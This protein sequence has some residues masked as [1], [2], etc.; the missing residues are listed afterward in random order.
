M[1]GRTPTAAE[2]GSL[3]AERLAWSLVRNVREHPGK[4][5][6]QMPTLERREDG[7]VRLSPGAALSP[8][9]DMQANCI[10]HAVDRGRPTDGGSADGEQ[11]LARVAVRHCGEDRSSRAHVLVGLSRD[12][13]GSRPGWE[14][15]HWQEQK[16]R[17]LSKRD[18]LGVRLVAMESHEGVRRGSVAICLS[19]LTDEVDLDHVAESGVGLH[20]LLHG[21]HEEDMGPGQEVDSRHRHAAEGFADSADPSLTE[22]LLRVQVARMNDAEH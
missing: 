3:L 11:H 5:L 14:V 15:M 2:A 20:D 10:G 19:E 6:G 16:F 12:E 7:R 1:V 21:L 22:A 18:S 9:I 13:T 8:C 17:A 4:L